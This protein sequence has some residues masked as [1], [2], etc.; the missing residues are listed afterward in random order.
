[1]SNPDWK[2]QEE[3]LAEVSDGFRQ[4]NSGSFDL[5]KGDVQGE[6]FL[7]DCKGTGKGYI[8]LTSDWIDKI[9]KEA[10]E[11][12]RTPCIEI[13]FKDSDKV[14]YKW[15]AMPE[16]EFFR[17]IEEPGISDDQFLYEEKESGQASLKIEDEE[18]CDLESKAY[19]DQ[20][21]IPVFRVDIEG[22]SFGRSRWAF[23]PRHEFL[24]LVDVF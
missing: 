14:Q 6:N 10:A 21:L 15:V 24:D 9:E 8:R 19:I 11:A 17:Y 22:S 5:M 4:P 18:F 3:N 12:D 23:M 2:E 7:A 1:M 16:T 13:C 20:D